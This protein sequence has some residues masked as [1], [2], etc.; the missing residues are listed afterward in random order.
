MQRGSLKVIIKNMKKEKEKEVSSLVN[1]I[2]E[3]MKKKNKV[4]SL[5]DLIM[6]GRNCPW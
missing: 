6:V 1:L 2:T 4:S 3:S 5:V